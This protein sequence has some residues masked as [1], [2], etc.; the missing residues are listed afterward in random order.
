MSEAEQF[1]EFATLK[2]FDSLHLS[3]LA[4]SLLVIVV[5][6]LIGRRLSA[7]TA[8]ERSGCSWRS[9]SEMVDYPNPASL[10][11]LTL[12]KDLTLLL[13]QCSHGIL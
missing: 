6:P 4:I 5:V 11:E 10:I 8:G 2:Y 7:V 3:T 12:V 1:S 9:R 13:C